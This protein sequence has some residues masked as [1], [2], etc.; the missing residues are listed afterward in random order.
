MRR[1][2]NTSYDD[3]VV[4]EFVIGFFRVNFG[5]NLKSNEKIKKIDLLSVDEENFGVEVEHGKWEG[6]FWKNDIYSLISQV[7]YRTANI[8]DRK[9][10]YWKDEI[11]YY[12]KI[13]KNHSATKNIFVRTNKDF[14]Q[15]LI[16]RPE[17]IRN[18][19]KLIRTKFQPKNSNEIENWL[20]FRREDVETY[21]LVEGGYVLDGFTENKNFIKTIWNKITHLLK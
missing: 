15:I 14:S 3:T 12:G 1:L 11:K 19:D 10:K 17:T 9:E 18:N 21:N 8:P 7:G 20:S 13:K 6:D 4:R 16:I 5:I 2:K